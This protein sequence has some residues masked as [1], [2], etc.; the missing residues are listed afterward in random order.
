MRA[1]E[2]RI[3]INQNDN[4]N[5]ILNKLNIEDEQYEKEAIQ[6]DTLS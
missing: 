4:T 5:D 3:V 2:S 6:N 1:R